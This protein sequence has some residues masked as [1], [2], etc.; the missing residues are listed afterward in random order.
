MIGEAPKSSA[1]SLTLARTLEQT[2]GFQA[3]FS[4]GIEYSSTNDWLKASRSSDVGI[5]VKYG[6]LDSFLLR[7]LGLAVASGLPIIRWW[8]GSDVL[9]ALT[10]KHIKASAVSLDK[11]TTKQIAVSPHLV[12]ELGSIGIASDYIPSVVDTAEP[13]PSS[14]FTQ[15][16]LLVYLP[17]DRLDFYGAP[18]VQIAIE[19]NPDVQ[20]LIVADESHSLAHFSNVQSLG[21]VS[22]INSLWDQVGGLLR[23]TQHDGMPRMVIDALMREK[24]VIYSWPFPGCQ[25][26]QQ[27]HQLFSEI[28]VFKKM[29]SPN[30]IGPSKVR[31][32]ITPNPTDLWANLIRTTA[33]NFC[34]RD[35]FRGAL[36]SLKSEWDLRVR[37]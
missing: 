15:R 28:N 37:C 27:P 23:L 16:A 3:F 11:I 14:C 5:V 8:V 29:D 30:I 22:D 34:W 7:Q 31:G 9:Y 24:W 25:L 20:F 10:D 21:W 26:A 6:K 19:E 17:T 36:S 13:L 33:K 18:A 1:P 12:D 35:R 32:I 4:D 2:H